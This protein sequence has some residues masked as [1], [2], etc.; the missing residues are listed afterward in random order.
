MLRTIALCGSLIAMSAPCAPAAP[1]APRQNPTES[2]SP[3]KTTSDAVAAALEM[4]LAGKNPARLSA[5]RERVAAAPDDAAAHWHLGEVQVAGEWVPWERAGSQTARREELERYHAIRSG[6]QANVPDQLYVANEAKSLRL[7]D[8]ERA[9]L[10]QVIALDPTHREAHER[11]GDV[12]SNGLWIPRETAVRSLQEQMRWQENQK[13]YRD[14]ADSLVRRIRN[15]STSATAQRAPDFTSWNH[16]D[17]VFPL[18]QAIG[19][20]GDSLH[21]AYLT[22]LS[23]FPCYEATIAIAR[24]AIFSEHA[25][26]RVQAIE[27]LKSRSAE[28]Y[29]RELIAS[30]KEI[31]VAPTVETLSG[32]GAHLF[33][34]E[35]RDL[36]TVC[37]TRVVLRHPVLVINF[38]SRRWNYN[39]YVDNL[40]GD[41]QF[42][43]DLAEMWKASTEIQA[44]EMEHR[45]RRVYRAL[46]G[47]LDR[48]IGAAEDAWRAWHDVSDTEPGQSRVSK[49]YEQSWY[50]DRRGRVQKSDSQV[51]VFRRIQQSCLAAGTLIQTETGPRP[52]ETIAPGDRVLAQDVE[53][54]EL[55]LKPV[56]AQTHRE[57]AKCMRLR[58]AGQE[59]VCSQGHPFW[60]NGIGWV[61]ARALRPGMPLHT[62]LGA[63]EVVSSDPVGEGEVYNLVVA[64]AHTYFVGTENA[65]LTHDVTHRPPTNSLIPGLQPLWNALNEGADSGS[66][67]VTAR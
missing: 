14:E 3:L 57:K 20:A 51:G 1:P 44:A 50:F 43:R 37:T 48:S 63:T 64:D 28:D 38:R 19:D 6:R 17:R 29:M 67:P 61:Q 52:V 59:L 42:N 36:D 11:L 26:I 31:R 49:N 45:N 25:E 54:G 7:V 8:E 10:A 13:A 22:W 30:V 34:T 18:E 21:R 24:Q 47:V 60:I 55:S 66:K 23:D 41:H 5:L 46:S 9:H 58:T 53:T 65:F 40:G 33:R 27:S 32:Q 2:A 4:E 16:P 35:W 12:L 15:R 39:F 56:L 62:V